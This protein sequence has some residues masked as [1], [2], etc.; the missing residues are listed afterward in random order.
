MYIFR[1]HYP[2]FEND[3]LKIDCSKIEDAADDTQGHVC[4]HNVVFESIQY[5]YVYA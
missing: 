5:F 1:K 4:I 2:Y 3:L